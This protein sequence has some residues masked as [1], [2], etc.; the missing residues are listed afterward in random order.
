MT[1]RRAVLGDEPT[2]RSLRLEALS[3]A[4]DAFG[5]TYARE[6]ARTTADWQ[7]W[8][9]PG[10]TLIFEQSGIARGLVAGMPDADDPAVTHLLAMWVHPSLRGTGAADAL[11]DALL[12]WARERKAHRVRLMVI[13]S[14]QRAQGLYLRYGFRLTGHQTVR[15]RD[16]AI[17][18]QMER[19]LAG[20]AG[21]T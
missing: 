19:L 20:E 14:N 4:P 16:G 15:E 2:L 8:L 17:E 3:D 7:R 11:V 10:V 13:A 9:A 5:S 18:L 6:V 21:A 12:A 1:V